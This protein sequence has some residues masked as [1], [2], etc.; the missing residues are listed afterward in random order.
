MPGNRDSR[1]KFQART[2]NAPT[3]YAIQT[4]MKLG[5]INWIPSSQVQVERK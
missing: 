2:E 5:G 1:M 3:F 4:I